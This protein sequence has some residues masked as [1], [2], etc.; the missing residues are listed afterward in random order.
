MTRQLHKYWI[1]PILHGA[2][3]AVRV[4][5]V[6]IGARAPCARPPSSASTPPN[7]VCRSHL[8]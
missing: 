5:A 4:L 8:G 1:D 3:L 2:M 6:R 7:Q